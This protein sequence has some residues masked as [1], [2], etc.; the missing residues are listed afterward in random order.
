MQHHLKCIR[1]AP[2]LSVYYCCTLTFG[3]RSVF[4]N[5]RKTRR[6]RATAPADLE[7]SRRV[8]VNLFST[9]LLYRN[10][11]TVDLIDST[12][13]PHFVVFSPRNWSAVRKGSKLGSGLI[14]RV[15]GRRARWKIGTKV[16]LIFICKAVLQLGA[17]YT[18]HLSRSDIAELP[19]RELLIHNPSD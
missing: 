2:V 16:L 9:A 17:P 11:Q 1:A 8:G 5:H 3:G 4:S 18:Y 13:Y 6:S 15:V 10:I 12:R 14:Y 19:R 7:H